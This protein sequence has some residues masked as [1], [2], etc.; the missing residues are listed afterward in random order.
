MLPRVV[1]ICPSVNRP[2]FL[3][4]ARKCFEAQT[5]PNKRLYVLDTG[6]PPFVAMSIGNLRNV[7]CQAAEDADVIAHWDDDDWSYPDRLTEQ[8]A[9][10]D[11]RVLYPGRRLSRY[12]LF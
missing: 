2:R 11:L 12:A 8:V 7:M 4:R 9:L 1:C 5:Y 3:L 10:F 6:F